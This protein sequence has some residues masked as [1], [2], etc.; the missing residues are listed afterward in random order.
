MIDAYRGRRQQIRLLS[1]RRTRRLA[2]RTRA[3]GA[4][5]RQADLTDGPTLRGRAQCGSLHDRGLRCP[6]SG[7]E[8]SQHRRIFLEDAIGTT[9]TTQPLERRPVHRA[10]VDL[11]GGR[12]RRAHRGRSRRARCLRRPTGRR[13]TPGHRGRCRR[14][15]LHDLASE[16]ARGDDHHPVEITRGLERSEERCKPAGKVMEQRLM[17]LDLVSVGVEASDPDGE[18]TGADSHRN[19]VRGSRDGSTAVRPLQ[20]RILVGKTVA[21]GGCGGRATASRVPGIACC[22]GGSVRHSGRT[23]SQ[24]RPPQG[25]LR[26]RRDPSRG[27]GR[28]ANGGGRRLRR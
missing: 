28:C 19:D 15:V 1:L 3:L 8:Q 24:G 14:A 22:G 7:G 17:V 21:A 11:S 12:H 18:D 25:H 5:S 16:L 2:R 20:G 10:G 23:P 6:A 4:D 26:P 9:R 13:R 27:E